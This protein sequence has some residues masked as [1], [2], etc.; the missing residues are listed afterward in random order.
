MVTI[1][2]SRTQVNM[3]VPPYVVCRVEAPCPL[4]AEAYTALGELA[5]ALE[6]AAARLG[7]HLDD[8]DSD[9]V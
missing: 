2:E 6:L 5:A 8:D 1:V 9:G 7:R 4:P 3:S